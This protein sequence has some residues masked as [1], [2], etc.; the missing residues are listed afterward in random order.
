MLHNIH[1][2]VNILVLGSSVKIKVG[3][4]NFFVDITW[5]DWILDRLL[6]KRRIYHSG[7]INMLVSRKIGHNLSKDKPLN[8]EKCCENSSRSHWRSNAASMNFAENY[9]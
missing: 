9:M 6:R 8:S 3:F 1:A 4:G 5:E 7:H 2:M